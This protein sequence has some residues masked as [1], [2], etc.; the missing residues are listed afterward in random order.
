MVEN[1]TAYLMLFLVHRCVLPSLLRF[2]RDIE[3][4]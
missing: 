4:P 1:G 3:Y 2:W